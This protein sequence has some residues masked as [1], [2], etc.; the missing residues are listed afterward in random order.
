LIGI[1]R[2]KKSPGNNKFEN[3]SNLNFISSLST[4]NMN[5]HMI[6][7]S[8]GSE[9]NNLN[10]DEFERAVQVE[11]KRLEDEMFRQMKL[12]NIHIDENIMSDRHDIPEQQQYIPSSDDSFKNFSNKS[13]IT[14]DKDKDTRRKL[15]LDQRAI[16]ESQIEETKQ[17]K[18]YERQRELEDDRM[19][20]RSFQQQ[21]V[22]LSSS[23]QPSPSSSKFRTQARTQMMRDV[24]GTMS[25]L[26]RD[27]N[28]ENDSQSPVHSPSNNNNS[29]AFYDSETRSENESDV[30][31]ATATVYSNP[32]TWKPSSIHRNVSDSKAT[33][34]AQR[35]AL[36]QQVA[37][38]RR[39]KESEKLRER[40]DDERRLQQEAAETAR[41]AQEKQRIRD[42]L[43]LQEAED[44]KFKQSR[45]E[46]EALRR[47]G[48]MHI[49]IDKAFD[50]VLP[51]S[52][53]LQHLP[54]HEYDGDDVGDH[55]ALVEGINQ[56]LIPSSN[57][58][59]IHEGFN[60]KGDGDDDDN[61]NFEESGIETF[62]FKLRVD[63]PENI[64]LT[65]DDI[66]KFQL[67]RRLL[68]SDPS[69]ESEAGNH[70]IKKSESTDPS[71]MRVETRLL[72]AGGH[73]WNPSTSDQHINNS[74]SYNQGY[75]GRSKQQALPE[76]SMEQSMM[77]ESLFLF[78]PIT[79]RSNKES[80]S[81]QHDYRIRH[82]RHQQSSLG[83]LQSLNSTVSPV[84][85]TYES[86]LLP[87][88]TQQSNEPE[89]LIVP[90]SFTRAESGKS[91]STLAY[92]PSAK[93][94]P[95]S[96]ATSS[97]LPVSRPSTPMTTPSTSLT[98][99]PPLRESSRPASA[100]ALALTTTTTNARSNPSASLSLPPIRS[101]SGLLRPS[102]SAVGMAL[103]ESRPGSALP[104]L[105]PTQPVNE[106]AFFKEEAHL[107]EEIERS[108]QS[109]SLRRI[110]EE[111]KLLDGN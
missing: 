31:R 100:S 61:D 44:L 42:E 99:L 108:T 1:K 104:S 2:P 56:L 7:N 87:V 110:L 43:R 92:V 53:T 33:Q 21:S 77:S 39:R 102:S 85:S 111:I 86:R 103:P 24:Y 72:S 46:L 57:L 8:S 71:Q 64:V 70:Y 66:K 9:S 79:A 4:I 82:E 15:I 88:R 50:P 14:S 11:M 10:D 93:L 16:L 73:V 12:A 26:L 96:A 107:F 19:R 101:S 58:P 22:D 94:R 109:A 80:L 52:S 76:V 51:A 81:S 40:Y 13:N 105:Y 30:G 3:E 5:E 75:D 28:N 23:Q 38:A 83:V 84:L 49:M 29:P 59:S 74:N 17:R 68:A 37:E 67:L 89:V 36:D 41:V 45:G 97:A 47:K 78:V 95:S 63:E 60:E 27:N 6:T 62:P 20:L 90:N 69:L 35:A 65:K 98:H 25:N 54:I 48:K 18:A 91:K 32:S 106:T 55:E 34:L